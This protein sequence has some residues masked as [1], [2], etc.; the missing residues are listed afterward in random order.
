MIVYCATDPN[1][2]NLYFDLWA[3][4]MNQ[5]YPDMHKIVAVYNPTAKIK[6]KCSQH[7][8]E[9]RTATLPNNPTRPHF[10]L[11]RW[12]NLPYDTN[13]LILETQVNC[14]PVKTQHFE[15]SQSVEHL[16]IS[17][18]K[19]EKPGGVSAAVFTRSGAEKTVEQANRMLSDPPDS[20]HQINHWQAQN[21][22]TDYSVTEQQF[23]NTDSM[24][25]SSTC[26]ITAGTSQNYT[27]TQK[28]EILKHYLNKSAEGKMTDE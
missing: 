3:A 13:E 24:L 16:R 20:D 4:Q 19:R 7:S 25:E 26:W 10:Y 15:Q 28:I 27:A 6:E 2:F 14:L 17:R 18:W 22:T 9:L 5:H 21:L 1:Y 8:V 12:L 23:K 11:L